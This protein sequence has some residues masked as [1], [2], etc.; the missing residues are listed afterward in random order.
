[1][2]FVFDLDGTICFKGKPVSSS[3]CKALREIEEMGHELLFASAR[4]IRDIV[5][6]LDE[7]FHSFTL[8]G[9]NGSLVSQKGSITHITA[10]SQQTLEKIIDLIQV[11]EAT[12]LI[13]SQWDYAF[14]GVENHPIL[15]NVDPSKLAKRVELNDLNSIVKILILSSNSMEEL[16]EK[17]RELDIVVHRH[18]GENLIDCS[19]SGIHKW[20]ALKNIGVKEK[21]FIAFG[22][23]S[24]D[25]T[26]FQHALHSVMIG[27]N[28]DLKPFS[29]ESILMEDNYEN[30]IVLKLQEL[31]VR[32]Q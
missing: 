27:E 4:P 26:M 24:N 28:E 5:P 10:F 8:I 9:G 21:E 22:N 29:S 17:L 32:Y 16:S 18:H 6:V 20:S 12:Y 13:D 1:M 7:C 25:I 14:T 30:S 11:Y 31:A 3:L 2:K 23:D 19:P 15:K